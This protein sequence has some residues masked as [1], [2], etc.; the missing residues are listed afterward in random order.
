M[1][2]TDVKLWPALDLGKIFA[3]L[4]EKTDHGR[5]YVGK[6]GNTILSKA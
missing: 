6:Y 2:S 1:W 3:F 4:M 5:E